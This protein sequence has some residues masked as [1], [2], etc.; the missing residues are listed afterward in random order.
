M[1]PHPVPV[2]LSRHERSEGLTAAFHRPRMIRGS[3]PFILREQHAALHGD[4]ETRMAL[5]FDERLNHRRIGWLVLVNF[6]LCVGVGGIAYGLT[7]K[8]VEAALKW[9]G[10]FGALF[11]TFQ[12]VIFWL[13]S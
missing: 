13:F 11:G 8:S 3:A 5:M 9:L 12:G 7:N 6:L 4:V 2:I 1:L 10:G